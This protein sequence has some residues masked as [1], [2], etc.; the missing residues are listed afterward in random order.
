MSEEKGS[1]L[2]HHHTDLYSSE[3]R[4]GSFTALRDMEG[5]LQLVLLPL[6][7]VIYCVYQILSSR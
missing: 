5:C 3:D 4:S 7:G 1:Y 6:L 2:D